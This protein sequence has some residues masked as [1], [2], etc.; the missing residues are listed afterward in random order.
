MLYQAVLLDAQLPFSSL[1]AVLGFE[2][3]HTCIMSG[4][5]LSCLSVK[6]VIDNQDK[7]GKSVE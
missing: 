1:E 3:L 2:Y 7:R 4:Y 5:I 6:L